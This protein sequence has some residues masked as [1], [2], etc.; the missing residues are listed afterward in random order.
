MYIASR[1][2]SVIYKHTNVTFQKGEEIPLEMVPYVPQG[3]IERV[4][5]DYTE[6]EAEPQEPEVIEPAVVV[7]AAVAFEPTMKHTG[8]G[9]YDVVDSHR[10]KHRV[11]G[12]KAALALIHAD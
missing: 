4:E 3:K 6:V 8:A 10:V 2:F 11:R 1:L 7:E 12:K 5:Y 9:W